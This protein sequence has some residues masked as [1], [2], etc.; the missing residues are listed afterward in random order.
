MRAKRKN[1]REL[2]SELNE[3]AQMGHELESDRAMLARVNSKL[4]EP[5]VL[6]TERPSHRGR[7]AKFESPMS[8]M[9]M[10]QVTQTGRFLLASERGLRFRHPWCPLE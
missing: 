9:I 3:G 6:V 7:V 10:L 2:P 1:V 5:V 4:L 8:I